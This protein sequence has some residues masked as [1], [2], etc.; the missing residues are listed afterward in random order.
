MAILHALPLTHPVHYHW[1]NITIYSRTFALLSAM[2]KT[3]AMTVSAGNGWRCMMIMMVATIFGYFIGNTI[4]YIKCDVTTQIHR[5][6]RMSTDMVFYRCTLQTI[7][8]GSQNCHKKT[9]LVHAVWVEIDQT[10][11]R[12]PTRFI[13]DAIFVIQTIQQTLKNQNESNHFIL[14]VCWLC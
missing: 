9:V 10:I 13:D 1:I 5:W 11:Q 7:I 14:S 8:R 6:F 4:E 2:E 12:W 3:E